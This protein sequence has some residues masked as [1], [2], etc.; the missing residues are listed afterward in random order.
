MRKKKKSG[1]NT[2]L[3][4]IFFALIIC[5]IFASILVKVLLVVKSSKFAEGPTFSIFV[6]NSKENEIIT[7]HKD[8]NSISVIKLEEK[9]GD[10]YKFS[11][12]PVSSVYYSEDLDFEKPAGELTSDIFFGIPRSKNNLN[13]YDG[14][15]ILLMS[16]TINPK[17]IRRKEIPKE[18]AES[19]RDEIF[20]SLFSD[21]KIAQERLTI[22]IVN[23]TGEQGIGNRFSRI[24]SNIGGSVVLV[25][26]SE[27][28]MKSGI[29]TQNSSYTAGRLSEVL[30]FPLREGKMGG[31]GDIIVVIGQ[32]YKNLTKY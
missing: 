12:I 23:D 25:S 15:R 20:S 16:K 8:K 32:D 4:L 10:V 17:D 30:N 9:V 7:Y 5:A 29:Y 3:A 19:Q 31:I 24:A 11:E 26:S 14:I 2:S 28:N 27:K 13:T 18:L 1:R 6:S 21:P 22:Q